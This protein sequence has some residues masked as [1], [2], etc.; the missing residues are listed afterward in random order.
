[1]NEQQIYVFNQY[2]IDF[3]KKIKALA[4]DKKDVQKEARDILR[5]IRKNYTSMDKLSND[6][7]NF[8]NNQ[9]FWETYN[10]N[11][12]KEVISDELLT[13]NLYEDISVK[14]VTA[15]FK[16]HDLLL[17]YLCLMD[18]FMTPDIPV[19]QVTQLVQKLSNAKEYE[20][21]MAAITQEPLL[22]KLK[23]LLTLHKNQTV[24]KFEE[25]IKEIEQTSLGSLAK[26]ILKDIDINDLQNSL[27]GEGG[28]NIGNIFS[29][30][31]DSSSGLGKVINTVSQ[32]MISKLANGDI[33]QDELLKDAMSLA[34]KLPGML[35]GGMGSQ[36]GNLGDMLQ[37]FQQMGGAD[38]MKNMGFSGSQKNAAG[39]RLHSASRRQKTADRLRKKLDKNRE[40][41][42]QTEVEEHHD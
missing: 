37:Q 3:L 17:H 23:H 2:Y 7:V 11:E 32:S 13:K 10:A 42:I 33:K 22:S 6:Y 39:G 29:S 15:V 14:Q 34:T 26:E 12:N 20:E 30:L 4:K 16:T 40:N 25:D 36:L 38:F 35:P 21:G 24:S 8:L 28:P 27:A 41:N 18:M 9:S 1:M 19:E 5:A 31:Q